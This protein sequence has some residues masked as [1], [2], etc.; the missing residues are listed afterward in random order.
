LISDDPAGTDRGDGD[1]AE[2]DD[3][4]A[5]MALREEGAVFPR[6]VAV[7]EATGG[8]GFIRWVG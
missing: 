4:A 3:F 2:T 1:T 6:D 5:A 7:M 8:V